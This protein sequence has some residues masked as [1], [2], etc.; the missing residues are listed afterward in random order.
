MLIRSIL[1]SSE[2]MVGVA[3]F[4]LNLQ[5]R[6]LEQSIKQFFG[7]YYSFCRNFVEGQ[8]FSKTVNVSKKIKT[9]NF[10]GKAIK[11]LTDGEHV[12]LWDDGESVALAHQQAV[13]KS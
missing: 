3:F 9:H 7:L 13:Q 8:N 5:G 10:E 4:S 6:H 1:V 11:K 12:Q 2:S